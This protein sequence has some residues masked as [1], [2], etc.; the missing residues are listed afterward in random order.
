MA[1]VAEKTYV[2]Y[3]PKILRTMTEIKAEMGVENDVIKQWIEEGAPIAVGYA[4][5]KKRYSCE[6]AAL[7]AWRL[8]NGK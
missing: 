1:T 5:S 2:V 8:Q 7:Q 4:G 6:S 3:M